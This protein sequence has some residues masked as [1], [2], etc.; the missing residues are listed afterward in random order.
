MA[1]EAIP[2]PRPWRWPWTRAETILW[3]SLAGLGLIGQRALPRLLPYPWDMYAAQP[4]AWLLVAAAAWRLPRAASEQADRPL[5][6]TAAVIA[7]M[8]QVLASALAGIVQGFGRSPYAHHLTGLALNFWF[9]GTQ[10]LAWEL[11]RDRLTR[12]ARGATG[13]RVAG[14]WLV[15]TAVAVPWGGLSVGGSGEQMVQWAGKRLLPVAAENLLASYLVLGGGWTASLAYRGVLAA[16]EWGAPVLPDLSWAW[17]AFVGTV[18]PILSI[19]ALQR[20]LEPP[21]VEEEAT[22]AWSTLREWIWLAVFAVALLWFNTGM[23][24]VQPS[25]ISGISMEPTL[26]AGDIAITWR[27]DPA[28]VQIGDIVRFRDGEISI[29]HR[30]WRIEEQ[31]G[32]RVFI[33]RGDNNNVADEPWDESRLE[34]RL[35]LVVRKVGW[36]PVI[37]ARLL[38]AI[39][40]I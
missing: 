40:V 30:V 12:S 23:L 11:C 5:W 32:H 28:D 34:G 37:L 13:W 20:W 6:A 2:Y 27:V 22:A 9:V 8:T 39:G 4:L 36:I 17:A 16:F 3:L 10:L 38:R 26:K 33:T 29:L 21:A 35:V 1:Q 18:V 19:L 14:A 25:L 7:G 15:L 31:G 24:G